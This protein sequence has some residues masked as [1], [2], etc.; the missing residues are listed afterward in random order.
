MSGFFVIVVYFVNKMFFFSNINTK[1]DIEEGLYYQDR[2]RKNIVS[3]Q[4]LSLGATSSLYSYIC[5]SIQI[6]K[7]VIILNDSNNKYKE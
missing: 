3:S 4:S 5:L 7:I 6:T 2:A 1:L